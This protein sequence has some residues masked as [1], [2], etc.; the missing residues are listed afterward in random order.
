MRDL[1]MGAGN[2]TYMY[3]WMDGGWLVRE[4]FWGVGIAM[5]ES[6]YIDW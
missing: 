1:T 3:L 6:K 4:C 2:W 5:L